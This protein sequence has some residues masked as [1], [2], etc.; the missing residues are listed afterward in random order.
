MAFIGVLTKH[1][2]CFAK[3]C[4]WTTYKYAWVWATVSTEHMEGSSLHF[5]AY[6]TLATETGEATYAE[7]TYAEKYGHWKPLERLQVWND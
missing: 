2:Q 3:H 6:Y 4:Q 1:L 5:S 7:A